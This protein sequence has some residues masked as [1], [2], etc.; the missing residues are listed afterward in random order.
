[1]DN[2]IKKWCKE[3]AS[4]F[5]AKYFVSSYAFGSFVVDQK[6]ADSIRFNHTML[7]LSKLKR[8][9]RKV[10]KSYHKIKS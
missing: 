1:M 9:L 4:T 6:E 10:E 5:L 8:R 7:E 2:K 3:K